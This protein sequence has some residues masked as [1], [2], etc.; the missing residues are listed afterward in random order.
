[1]ATFVIF[2][3]EDFKYL[4][5]VNVLR[6]EILCA[7]VV[8]FGF[9]SEDFDLGV[10]FEMVPNAQHSVTSAPVIIMRRISAIAN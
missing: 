4:L 1:M 10:L 2:F 5:C 7:S 3:G 6:L 9:L 8:L